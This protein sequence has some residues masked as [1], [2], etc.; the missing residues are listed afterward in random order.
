[1][2]QHPGNSIANFR[3]AEAENEAK[4]NLPTNNYVS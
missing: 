2:Q 4:Y 3:I 1:M